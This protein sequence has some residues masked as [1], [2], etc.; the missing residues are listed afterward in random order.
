MLI[1][2]KTENFRKS[3]SRKTETISQFDYIQKRIK[4]P[5][6][7]I[8]IQSTLDLMDFGFNGHCFEL[9]NFLIFVFL[10]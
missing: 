8:G 1:Q 3:S 5:L 6:I 2:K 10:K 4:N 7:Q 9:Q